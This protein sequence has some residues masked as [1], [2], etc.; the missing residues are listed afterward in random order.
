MHIC[1]GLGTRSWIPKTLSLG[2]G[3]WIPSEYF[4]HPSCRNVDCSVFSHPV[5]VETR[6]DRSETSSRDADSMPGPALG[7]RTGR[8]PERNSVQQT[9]VDRQQRACWRGSYVPGSAVTSAGVTV[10]AADCQ[11]PVHTYALVWPLHTCT[12]Q[13]LIGADCRTTWLVWYGTG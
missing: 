6:M 10:L 12:P 1:N 13:D 8:L 2:T 9:A 4:S 3:S 11:F 5:R 7:D